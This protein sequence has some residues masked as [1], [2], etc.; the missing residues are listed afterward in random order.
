MR[1]LQQGKK[2]QLLLQEEEE[3]DLTLPDHPSKEPANKRA[4]R[5]ESSG[6]FSFLQQKRKKERNLI[7]LRAT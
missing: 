5:L 4:C 3:E 1:T 7:L 2:G 6:F